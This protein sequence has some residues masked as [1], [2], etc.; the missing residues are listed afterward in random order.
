MK[1]AST[2]LSSNKKFSPKTLLLLHRNKIKRNLKRKAR[3]QIK[4]LKQNHAKQLLSKEEKI[5]ELQS[6][7]KVARN[8]LVLSQSNLRIKKCYKTSSFRKCIQ[9]ATGSCLTKSSK[10][11][12]RKIGELLSGIPLFGNTDVTK[13]DE[14]IFGEGQFGQMSL[15]RINKLNTVAACKKINMKRCTRNDVL[16]EAIAG[17]TVAGSKYFP[18]VFGMLNESAILMEYFNESLSHGVVACSNLWEAVKMRSKPINPKAT[19]TDAIQAVLYLHGE[20]ILHNDLKADNFV[21]TSD[22]LK[23]IDFGK[24]TMIISPKVYSIKPGSDLS[25][26]YNTYHR[27]L[28][29]ELRNVPGSKQSVFTD[30]YSLGYMFKHVGPMLQ[31]DEIVSSGRHMKVQEAEFRTPLTKALQIVQSFDM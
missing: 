7:V 30:I 10:D 21:L 29:Y 31:C 15:V 17:L 18:Y 13:I 5:A 12:K 27:H 9:I 28:A 20:K 25:K 4:R 19:F 23:L 26:Q 16:A 14:K 6:D 2:I 22:C 11:S 8:K 24:A 1:V 3:R